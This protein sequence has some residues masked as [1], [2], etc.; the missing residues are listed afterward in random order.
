MD[1]ACFLNPWQRN[2]I[3]R[4]WSESFG[5]T[6]EYI[7]LFIDRHIDSARCAAF[8]VDGRAQ[9]M[10]FLLDAPVRFGGEIFK[11]AYVYAA[12]TARSCRGKGL[13]R[14]LL[15]FVSEQSKTDFVCLVP[16]QASLFDYYSRSGFV[17][18]F[19]KKTVS[20]GAEALPAVIAAANASSGSLSA[21][22]AACIG[23]GV[24]WDDAAIR[25]ALEE[26]EFCSGRS[27]TVNDGASFGYAVTYVEGKTA[28][29]KEA[30]CD[31][32]LLGELADKISSLGCDEY[33]LD[34][35]YDGSGE[36]I[37]TGMLRAVS[38]LA[39]QA[40]IGGDAYLGLTLG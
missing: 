11:S 29:I 17:T 12:C 5:D 22:R 26:N 31:R 1:G 35:P 20:V 13:M 25:Y 23:N 24:L 15:D 3:V 9:S 39:K 30:A 7:D 18:A 19:Y 27:F 40:D 28:V 37:P 4:L 6:K 14:C 2:D 21:C 38:S 16:S 32:L 10:L 8:I 36:R 34:L 33:R